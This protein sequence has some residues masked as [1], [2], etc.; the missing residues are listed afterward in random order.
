MS[1]G[2]TYRLIVRVQGPGPPPAIRVRR[3]L[4]LALRCCGLRCVEVEEIEGVHQDVS[5]SKPRGWQHERE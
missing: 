4:K 1:G 5:E 3:L 2:P